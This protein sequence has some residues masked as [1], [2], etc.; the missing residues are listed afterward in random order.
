M[1]NQ[2][3]IP[4]ESADT[5]NFSLFKACNYIWLL[6]LHFAENGD[7]NRDD[8]KDDPH[9]F[10]DLVVTQFKILSTDYNDNSQL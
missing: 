7:E 1:E 5:G 8:V 2:F 10:L 3:P 4:S 9:R 6:R